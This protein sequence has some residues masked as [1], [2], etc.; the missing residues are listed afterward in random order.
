MTKVIELG[1]MIWHHCYKKESPP[2]YKLR[3][4]Q[5]K[6]NLFFHVKLSN[7]FTFH[8]FKSRE[9]NIILNMDMFK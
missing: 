2:Q 3:R 4:T 7:T 1:Q 6:I 9:Y 5:R 8:F